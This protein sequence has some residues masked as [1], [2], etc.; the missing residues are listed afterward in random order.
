M[1]PPDQT[2]AMAMTPPASSDSRLQR[3]GSYLRADPD[4]PLLLRD[5][6]S[7]AL[8]TREL[9]ACVAA[10]ERLREVDQVT[11]DDCVLLARAL[12]LDGRTSEA[13]AALNDAATRW[14]DD[15]LVAFEAAACHFSDRAFDAALDALPDLPAEEPLATEVCAM[16]VRLLH[17][18]GRMDDAL[19]L[20]NAFRATQPHEPVP[21]IRAMLPVLMDLSRVDDARALAQSLVQGTA[22]ADVLPYEAC[23][24][25]AAAALDCDDIETA[26][27]WTAQA[28]E[29]RQDDG[30][31][32]LLKGLADLRGGAAAPAID[33][34]E[35][36]S[37]LMPSHAGSHL[38]LGWACLAVR[39]LDRAQAAFDDA[40]HASPTFSETHGSLAVIA[41]MRL[42]SAE[43]KTLVK[44][45][46]RLD[47][48]C[49]SA[50]WAQQLLGG[51][52]APDQ[53]LRLATEVAAR[54]RAQR[55]PPSD[56]SPRA[57]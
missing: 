22:P 45:A 29:R 9:R 57:S 35:R 16:R 8:R 33:A 26:R 19:T 5:Y 37:A 42:Q 13:L 40:A 25:L 24:P 48:H 12:R 31:V 38:A 17:H 3:L 44:K 2:L 18:L 47:R 41:A 20:A 34:L 32:W 39:D 50:L 56:N 10:I 54:A 7:E 15:S 49:A 4:N 21:V 1:H 27:R 11:R 53:I 52:L 55:M 14:P 51:K 36:A 30:R 23:E 6:A 43:A 28:L 46:Q